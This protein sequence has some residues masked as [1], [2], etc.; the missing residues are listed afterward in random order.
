MSG[1]EWAGP[2]SASV[3]ALLDIL[4][5]LLIGQWLN[6]RGKPG[7]QLPS[8]LGLVFCASLLVNSASMAGVPLWAAFAALP[9]VL[10]THYGL[11]W[12]AGAT[13][14]AALL[15]DN[16]YRNG[17]ASTAVIIVLFVYFRACTGH[18]ADAGMFS[19]AALVHTVHL[20]AAGAWA[21]SVLVFLAQHRKL[22]QEGKWF[23]SQSARH[24]S[25]VA[26]WA[27]MV[28]VLTG[29][30]NAWRVLQLG[31]S[32]V[33][34]WQQPWSVILKTKLALVAI[35]VLLGATNRWSIM[36]A[37]D[38]N[39]QRAQ[40]QFMALLLLEAVVFVGV[41]GCAAVLGSTSPPM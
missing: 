7:W 27:V 23:D 4:I 33:E 34:P 15:L 25:Q 28:V 21:G 14:I 1:F 5:A 8:L 41:I 39:Q 12:L 11:M 2:A 30:A 26:L 10:H 38:L 37:L 29:A 40:R 9:L 16:R 32:A 20:L 22:R 13:C 3:A 36:P 6:T 35:A 31:A 17:R 24:L 18:V 19:L